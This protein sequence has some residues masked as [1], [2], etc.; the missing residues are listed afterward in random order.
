MSDIVD[1]FLLS[2]LNENAYNEIFN[3][4]AEQDCTA[5]EYLECIAKYTGSSLIHMNI[6]YT[7]SVCLANVIDGI[8]KVMF[9]KAGF[10]NKGRIDFLAKDH[11]CDISKARRVLGYAPQINLDTGIRLSVEWAK[12]KGYL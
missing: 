1:G 12:E 10:V 7:M 6:G 4:G 11:S 5:K 9:K 8:S 3:L 2:V